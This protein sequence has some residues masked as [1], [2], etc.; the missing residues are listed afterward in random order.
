VKRRSF[1]TG[2]SAA[3]ALVQAQVTG[4]KSRNASQASADTRWARSAARKRE[5]TKDVSWPNHE[6]F[7]FLQRRGTHFE[8]EADI[9]ERQHDPA[10]IHKM[11]EAGVRYG[12]L[13]FYKG[14]GLEYE[15]P[16]IEKTRLA[17]ALMHEHGMKVSLYVAGTMFIESFY[18][19][20]PEAEQWE[21]RDQNNRPVPYMQTQTFRHYACPND[22]AYRAYMKKVVRIGVQDI[23]ADQ[24][25][26]DNVQLQP[27]PKSCRCQRC[28]RGFHEF[29]RR[30]YPTGEA[31]LRRFGLPE[32]DWLRVNEW[33]VY[34]TPDSVTAVDDP[35]LQEW[36]RF[37]CEAMARHYT[38][39]CD[40]IKS[41]NP[42]VSVGFNLK[43]IYGFNRMWL[44][45]VYHSDY[46]G[47]CDFMPFDVNGMEARLDEKTG[48]LISEI[49]SYKLARTLD[50]SCD[51]NMYDELNAA[52]RMAFNYQKQV[53]GFGV[54]GGPFLQGGFN[55][56]TPIMEFFREYNDRYLTGTTNIADVAVLRNWPSMA[57]SIGPTL[58]P[59]ILMEQVLI[60]H[61]VPFDIL[62]EEQLDRV[63]RYRAVVLAGQE[64]LS[65]KHIDALLTYARNGGTLLFTGNTGQFNEWRERRR[66][67]PLL[68]RME[69]TD[70]VSVRNEGKGKLVYIP[71]ILQAG[72]SAA[73]GHDAEN[74][75][76]VASSDLT[77]HHFPPQQWVLPRNHQ[78]IYQAILDNVTGGLSVASDAPLTTVMEVLNRKATRESILQFVNFDRKN[79]VA[80]IPVVLKAQ[81]NAPVKSVVCYSPD[82][83]A[84][85]QVPFQQTG[86]GVS[87]T[88]PATR[89][90]SMIVVAHG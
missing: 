20:V 21:Q 75:E 38:E 53:P 73:G 18:R 52:V 85:I 57:Y 7:I 45:G 12:R 31:A 35:V 36:I 68:G 78:E 80:A 22:M 82:S 55:A 77:N 89:V 83:E 6:P 46:C 50:M 90:Y 23:K 4:P 49:R 28:M 48:A 54:Q 42:A 43:G 19:E 25:F 2:L 56:F 63:G 51:D 30:K 44:N 40:H 13:H 71:A 9:Y 14:F 88:A 65:A 67:N 15:K 37:R 74:P 79:P 32:V 87:F 61:R 59:T 11:A 16:D 72:R 1:I 29:L 27:E 3:G 64:C 47:K 17:A 84:P 10:N 34:N 69:R 66:S 81:F 76:I 8:D 60:Q 33:D 41:L 70:A 62:Y 58:A 26:F 5:L 39:L 86:G 24:I